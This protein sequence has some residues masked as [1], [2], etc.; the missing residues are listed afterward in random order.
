MKSG[1]AP[2]GG[3]N[4]T[5]LLLGRLPDGSWSAPSSICPNFASAGLLIGFDITDVRIYAN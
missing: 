5:G 4:G 1:M 3:M 2:F